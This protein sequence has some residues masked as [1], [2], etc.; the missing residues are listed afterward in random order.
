MNLQ[1]Y[2]MPTLSGRA[3]TPKA[4][5]VPSAR[6]PLQPVHAALAPIPLTCILRGL[7]SFAC[8]S[9]AGTSMTILCLM[10][11]P[12]FEEAFEAEVAA[13]HLPGAAV[14]AVWKDASGMGC[15]LLTSPRR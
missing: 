11:F 5:Q 13:Q 9:R 1:M 15:F 14:A 3:L 6:T 8:P 10:N 12:N 7:D 4:A 2:L